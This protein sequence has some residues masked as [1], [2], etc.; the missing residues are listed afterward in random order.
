MNS[1]AFFRVL[2]RERAAFAAERA[3]L[4]ETICRLAGQPSVPTE[5]DLW[6]V[7]RDDDRERLARD[8]ADDLVD[9]DQ[10]PD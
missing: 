9:Y 5:Q 4:I 2:E 8:E 1:R 7:Q 6:M 3:V 10:L